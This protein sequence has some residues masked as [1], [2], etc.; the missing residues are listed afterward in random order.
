MGLYGVVARRCDLPIVGH[1]GRGVG[2]ASG[3][4]GRS[5]ARG[6]E[7]RVVS[8]RE[9]GSGARLAKELVVARSRRGG[10]TAAEQSKRPTSLGPRA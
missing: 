4:G 7:E 2:G 10:H 1:R 3:D 9:G 8:G 5:R 6:S